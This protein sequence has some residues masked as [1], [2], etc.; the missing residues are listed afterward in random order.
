MDDSQTTFQGAVT[1]WI[2]AL[3][4]FVGVSGVLTLIQGRDAIT[5][6]DD[7]AETSV[8]WL[9]Y[10]ALALITVAII[11]AQVASW[12]LPKRPAAWA[13]AMASGAAPGGRTAAAWWQLWVSVG[14]AVAAVVCVAIASGII[15]FG[16]EEQGTYALTVP[17]PVVDG[18]PGSGTVFCGWLLTDLTGAM[19]LRPRPTESPALP[20]AVSD[21]AKLAEVDNCPEIATTP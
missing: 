11:V 14:T 16:A 12:A 7:S 18:T 4:G 9:L 1:R 20:V 8:A 15:W 3:G 19:E 10:G 17:G 2:G 6:L 21:Y 13:S 5:R